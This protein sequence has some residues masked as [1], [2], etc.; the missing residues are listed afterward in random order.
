M[1]ITAAKIVINPEV[2]L[3][4]KDYVFHRNSEKGEVNVYNNS[5]FNDLKIQQF[6]EIK[7]SENTNKPLKKKISNIVNN[8]KNYI[9]EGSELK[10]VHNDS[11]Y[12]SDMIKSN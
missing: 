11:K 8:D 2:S 1:G 4:K 6:I 5:S 9:Y 12:L 7:Q 10:I 3:P